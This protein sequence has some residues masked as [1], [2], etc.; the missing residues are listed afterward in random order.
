MS[1]CNS[2]VRLM[3]DSSS[4]MRLSFSNAAIFVTIWC[5]AATALGINPPS[6]P[7]QIYVLVL[8]LFQFLNYNE[9]TSID[10]CILHH[11]CCCCCCPVT[12]MRGHSVVPFLQ[13]LQKSNTALPVM[14]SST[15]SNRSNT[16]CSRSSRLP[17]CADANEKNNLVVVVDATAA[18]VSSLMQCKVRYSTIRSR[19]ITFNCSTISH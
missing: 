2:S 8:T 19:W 10:R 18:V 4:G 12:M 5:C 11:S 13:V 3:S 14:T 16:I 7:P 6:L 9:Q 17:C 1:G 15:R